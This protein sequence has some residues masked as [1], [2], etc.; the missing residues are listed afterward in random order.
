MQWDTSAHAGFTT[1]TSW[2]RVNDDYKDCNVAAQVDDP[3]SVLGFWKR[4][5]QTRKAHD[6][7]VSRACARSP[8]D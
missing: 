8:F 5:L 7:L 1:G 2:M 3:D 6:V 4:A